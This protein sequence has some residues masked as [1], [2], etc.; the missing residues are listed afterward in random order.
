MERCNPFLINHFHSLF[1]SMEGGGVPPCY[2]PFSLFQFP[3]PRRVRGFWCFHESPIK[4][5]RSAVNGERS[6][7][8]LFPLPPPV[9]SHQSPV[10]LL[11][12]P[13]FS[14]TSNNQILQPL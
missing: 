8:A 9:T 1:H 10:T 4:D 11:A 5:Y 6:T 3:M 7:V 13:L 14:T 2:F 12:P